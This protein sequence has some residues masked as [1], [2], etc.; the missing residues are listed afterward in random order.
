MLE[1]GEPVKIDDLARRM[2]RM[3]GLRPDV[4]IEIVYTGVRPGEKL[5]EELVLDGDERFLTE[6]PMIS[7]IESHKVPSGKVQLAKLYELAEAEHSTALVPALM[8]MCRDGSP[9]ALSRPI[10]ASA[11]G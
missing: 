8:E 2:I 4:D 9:Q 10:D 11:A 7:R 1:M 3:R 5:H 6:H